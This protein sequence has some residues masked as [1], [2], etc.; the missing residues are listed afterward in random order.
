MGANIH[1]IDGPM[2][3]ALKLPVVNPKPTKLTVVGG[4]QLIPDYGVFKVNL[5]PNLDGEY[6]EVNCQGMNP[7]TSHFR[8]YSLDE[9]N[10]EVKEVC[11]SKKSSS[12]TVEEVASLPK[13]IGGSA[14][15]LL[16]GIKETRIHPTPLFTLPSG[17]GVY[18]SPF[19][20]KFGSRICFGGP[21]RV[22]S[23]A[24]QQNSHNTS[25]AVMLVQEFSNFQ[26]SVF[27][28]NFIPYSEEFMPLESQENIRSLEFRTTIDMKS[29]CQVESN[30]LSES[31]FTDAGCD[32]SPDSHIA[33]EECDSQSCNKMEQNKDLIQTILH[34]GI[35]Q[36]TILN[37]ELRELL[38]SDDTEGMVNYR[39]PECS[40][41]Q[42]CK[43]SGK[44][45]RCKSQLS[46]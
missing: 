7:V 43:E 42:K 12:L 30:R 34:C 15:H 41:C 23:K 44:L 8:R 17:L 35:H 14:V 10:Q 22:F 13:Y 19:K 3:E 2:A 9:I 20:D 5:G 45:C 37:N 6:F 28:N 24:N 39:C 16:L 31:D 29:G 21:H 32:I 1:L 25:H 40:K 33:L 18:R 26:N 36:A 4:A 46:N 38:D 11:T 27:G